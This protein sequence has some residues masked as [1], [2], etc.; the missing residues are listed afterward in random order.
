[1]TLRLAAVIVLLLCVGGL[2]LAATITFYAIVD[3]VNARL[4]SEE[5]FELLGWYGKKSLRLKSEYRRLYPQGRLLWREG[6]LATA[7]VICLTLAAA[8]IGFS[9]PMV[10]WLGGGGALLLWFTYLRKPPTS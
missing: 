1:M 2:G 5:Q 6:V 4:P 3:A 10:A 8:V 9:F 7:G